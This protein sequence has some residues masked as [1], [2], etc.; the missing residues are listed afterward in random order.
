MSLPK[1]SAHRGG[2]EDEYPPNSLEAFRAV[3][4][5]G[6]DMIE[7]DVRTTLD[8]KFITCHD[9]HVILRGG[10][11]RLIEQLTEAEVFA[12]APDA[13][14][15]SDV[16]ALI[17]GKALGHVDLKDTRL[18]VE[19]AD[20]CQRMLGKDG[21]VL[22]TLEDVSVRRL[23]TQRPHL[24]VAL[25]LGRS[26]VGLGNLE[27]VRMR[28]SEIFP[29]RRIR[30]CDPNMLVLH[31]RLAK[32]G[33]LALAR[34]RGLPVLLWTINDPEMIAAVAVDPRYWGYTTDFPRLAI[35][36]R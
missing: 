2:P 13:A 10:E 17:K 19:I 20:A 23:R 9:D 1:L 22:S 4:D 7:F 32:V 18:E 28:L 25:T 30:R 8:G 36:L 11:I 16:L 6:V 35:R 29:Q 24:T 5:V 15:L 21:F 31:H 34:R 3:L 14:S 27:A 12:A 33:V 26:T